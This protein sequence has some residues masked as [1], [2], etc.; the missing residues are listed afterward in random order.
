MRRARRGIVTVPV[1]CGHAMF[2][3]RLKQ[4]ASTLEVLVSRYPLMRVHSQTDPGAAPPTPQRE[5]SSEPEQDFD[6]A[7]WPRV[8]RSDQAAC[9]C[10]QSP[11]EENRSECSHSVTL[12]LLLFFGLVCSELLVRFRVQCWPQWSFDGLWPVFHNK[13]QAHLGNKRSDADK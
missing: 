10:S 6:S 8:D 1:Y 2:W 9:T 11:A 12:V 3:Q 13:R 4:I 5:Y 7:W